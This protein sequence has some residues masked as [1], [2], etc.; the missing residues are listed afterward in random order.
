M[1][2]DEL[3]GG[4]VAL[5]LGVLQRGAA[6]SA[7]QL[8]VGLGSQQGPHACLFPLV[9]GLHQGGPT[10]IVLQVRV[11]RVLQENEQER[12]VAEACSIHERSAAEGVSQ[13]DARASLQQL[14]H[15]LQLVVVRG[16]MQ[17][18]EGT[19]QTFAS[20]LADRSSAERVD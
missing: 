4:C 11:G 12:V 5:G 18:G 15:D 3:R 1:L 7:E 8:G 13:V 6:A 14:P 16:G 10:I 17:K 9:S 2:P 20:A 19:W